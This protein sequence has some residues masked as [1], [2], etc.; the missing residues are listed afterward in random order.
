MASAAV[1]MIVPITC[2]RRTASP[3]LLT[4]ALPPATIVQDPL[5]RSV[6]PV[7]GRVLTVIRAFVIG[8]RAKDVEVAVEVDIDLAT[9]VAGDLDL[10]VALF[11][12]DLGAGHTSS[13]GVVERDALGFLDAGSGGLLLSG[14]ARAGSISDTCPDEQQH[15]ERRDYQQRLQVHRPGV[16]SITSSLLML[17]GRV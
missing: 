5:P 4:P 11:V 17:P 7:V 9:V 3:S 2:R 1:M 16:H 13:V 6:P 8:R 15:S 12:A 14:F 10:V